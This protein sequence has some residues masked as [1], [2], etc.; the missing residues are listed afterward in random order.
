MIR[1]RR[2]EG[3]LEQLRDSGLFEI[4]EVRVDGLLDR[5]R[6]VVWVPGRP[7]TLYEGA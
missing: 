4:E 5:N 6:W 3:E 2:I 1:Q 7:G